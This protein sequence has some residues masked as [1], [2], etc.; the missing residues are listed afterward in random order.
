MSVAIRCTAHCTVHTDHVKR[1][2]TL[3][4]N[5]GKN[6]DK[7]KG[8]A[9]VL[10]EVKGVCGDKKVE[11]HCSTVSKDIFYAVFNDSVVHTFCY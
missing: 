8:S 10:G 7:S 11:N 2:Q 5:D 6:A 9:G 3:V 1:D 4:I